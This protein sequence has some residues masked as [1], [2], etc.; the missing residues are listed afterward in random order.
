MIGVMTAIKPKNSHCFNRA[1]NPFQANPSPVSRCFLIRTCNGTT[2]KAK[3]NPDKEN[4]IMGQNIQPVLNRGMP[5][6]IAEAKPPAVI[7]ITPG[8]VNNLS[9]AIIPPAE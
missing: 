8:T 9:E 1:S 2:L 5:P 4:N 6:Y 7:I 3:N